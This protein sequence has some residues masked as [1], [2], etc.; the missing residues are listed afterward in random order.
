MEKKRSDAI[1]S[2]RPFKVVSSLGLKMAVAVFSL[3]TDY[4][5]TIILHCDRGG[6]EKRAGA[7]GKVKKELGGE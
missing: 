5:F 2:L 4:D 6:S 3:L 7:G 1:R